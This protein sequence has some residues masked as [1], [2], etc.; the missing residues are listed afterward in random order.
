MQADDQS[1]KFRG[2]DWPCDFSRLPL[3]EKTRG[4]ATMQGFAL[5]GR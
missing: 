5:S 3:V 2:Q 1:T 4:G